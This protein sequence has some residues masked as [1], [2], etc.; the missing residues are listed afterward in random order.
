[1]KKLV[2]FLFGLAFF[3][4]CEMTEKVY[5][6][7]D[8]SVKYAYDMDLTQIS[9]LLAMDKDEKLTEKFPIDT[10]MTVKGF[11]ESDIMGDKKKEVAQTENLEKVF[12][13]FQIHFKMNEENGFFSFFTKQKNVNQLNNV[14]VDMQKNMEEVEK[15]NKEDESEPFD[16]LFTKMFQSPSFSYDGKRFTRSGKVDISYMKEMEEDEKT[17]GLMAMFGVMNYKTEYHFPRPVKS[18]SDTSVLMSWDRKTIYLQK[19]LSELMKNQE[20][21]NFSLELED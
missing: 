10:I 14:L 7:E 5:I 17:M 9:P 13:D 15:E 18:I 11:F 16:K 4:S 8:E 3:T 2:L 12:K 21:Y 6:Y 20:A 1:M 19:P